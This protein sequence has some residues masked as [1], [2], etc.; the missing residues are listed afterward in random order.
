MSSMAKLSLPMLGF[1][2]MT[3]AIRTKL[4]TKDAKT[5]KKTSAAPKMIHIYKHI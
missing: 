5:E 4:I 1:T 2:T 3:V